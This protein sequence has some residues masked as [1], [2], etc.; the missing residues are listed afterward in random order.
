MDTKKGFLESDMFDSP[1]PNLAHLHGVALST[2]SYILSTMATK[3]GSRAGEG[4]PSGDD[5]PQ[6]WICTDN[7]PDELGKP[8]QRDCSCRGSD[9]GYAHL[10]CL[11]EYA[12]HKTKEWD[13]RDFDELFKI[14]Q[15]CSRCEQPYQN[16]IRVELAAEFASI[17]ETYYSDDQEMLVTALYQKLVSLANMVN[18]NIN[19]KQEAKQIAKKI[20]SLIEQMKA[21][22]SPLNRVQ[23]MYVKVYNCL[24]RITM[25]EKTEEGAQEALAHFEKHLDLSIATGL[26][27]EVAVAE[28]NIDLAKKKCGEVI[29]NEKKIELSQ[30]LYDVRLKRSGKGAL[31]TLNAGLCLVDD[32]LKAG[33][34]VE[35]QKLATNLATVSKQVH[36]SDHEVSKSMAKKLSRVNLCKAQ[37]NARLQAQRKSLGLAALILFLLL[38][39]TY[40]LRVGCCFVWWCG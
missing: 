6:C 2:H 36:G 3:T 29:S 31:N 35:A 14:W 11:V 10:S 34:L 13:G 26:T 38:G 1:M 8:L 17:V 22:E 24:G 7:G 21:R 18:L 40:G 19:S 20:L 25:K 16:G 30:K 5:V 33:R 12:K 9:A 28:Y 4:Q 15:E 39:F 23:H 37:Q 27:D 32:L